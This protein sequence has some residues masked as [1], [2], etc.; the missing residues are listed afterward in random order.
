MVANETHRDRLLELISAL[1]AGD[2]VREDVVGALKSEGID[3][4]DVLVE[5]LAQATRKDSRAQANASPLDP[6]RPRVAPRSDTIHRV[7]R[8]PFLLRGTLYDPSDIERF[9]G[10]ELHFVGGARDEHTLAIDDRD[11]MER[12]WQLSYIT[13]HAA[14]D[15][16]VYLAAKTEGVSPTGGG[17]P[18][19]WSLEPPPGGGGGPEG[20]GTAPGLS[21]PPRTIFYAV[22]CEHVNYEGST[23][24]SIG[25]S[26]DLTSVGWND[27]TSSMQNW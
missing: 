6:Q 10:Q 5:V 22:L 8:V 11:V 25:G 9:N 2:A 1:A 4:L 26:L 21:G 19:D 3:S 12:W 14:S 15:P 7:P 13:V 16:D 20:F 27:R 24:T 18:T 17:L 23:Y